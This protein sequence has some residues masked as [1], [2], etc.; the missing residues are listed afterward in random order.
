MGFPLAAALAGAWAAGLVVPEKPGSQATVGIGLGGLYSLVVIGRF[1][2]QLTT[3]HALLLF[4]APLLCVAF[5]LPL[6]RRLSP[7]LQTFA[8]LLLAGFLVGAV[9][10]SSAIEF[11]KNS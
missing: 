2:A 5:E 9:D 4:F 1:F 3:V 11:S 10:A 8:C 6:I 7:W